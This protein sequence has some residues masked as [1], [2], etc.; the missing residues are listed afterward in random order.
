MSTVTPTAACL[1]AAA[2]TRIDARDA[3]L[4][5]AD[6]LG[7]RRTELLTR[8]DETLDATLAARF[9]ERVARR[10]AGE[11]VAY[12][13]GRREFFGLSL[14]VGPEVL[15][16]RPDTEVLVERGVAVLAASPAAR[17]RVLDLGTGSGAIAI[18]VAS[19]VPHAEVVATDRS[20]DA[21]ALAAGNAVRCLGERPGGALVL[22]AGDWLAALPRE[23]APFDLILSNPPYIAA[24]DRH[25]EQGDLRFEPRG[26]LTD[27]GDGLSALRQIIRDAPAHLRAGAS[28]WLEH[29]YD[30]A[31]AVREQLLARGFGAVRS[32]ADLA[33]IARISGGVW[34]GG[35]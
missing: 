12:L 22:H 19:A 33:G 1:L 7:W 26:A 14:Q 24:G 10:A 20:A 30:Q 2:R 13:L 23:T 34:P 25:L 18:A 32:E 17:P 27:E 21:L 8:D 11:P 35:R 5:L 15:I 6:T 9:E 31:A 16:P 4:L 3:V 29:G 28:L